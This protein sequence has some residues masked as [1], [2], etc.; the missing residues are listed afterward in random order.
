MACAKAN[1]S[2]LLMTENTRTCHPLWATA[3][4]CLHCTGTERNEFVNPANGIDSTTGLG[5]W[6]PELRRAVMVVRPEFFAWSAQEQLAY[7]VKLPDEDREALVAALLREHGQRRPAALA[8]LESRGRV[9]LALQNRIN[10][11]LQ[12]LSGIGEDA[13][14]LN[15]HFAEGTSILDFET[16]LD[17]DRDD[18]T[19][20]QEANQREFEGYQPEPYT[21]ALYGTWARVLVEGQLCYLTLTMASGQLLDAM[22]EAA[23]AEIEARIPHH[24]VPGPDDGKRDERGSIRWDMRVDANGQETL[25]EEL[26]HRVWDEQSRRRREL[27]QQFCEQHRGVCFLDDHPWEHGDPNE[28]NLLVVFS[29][30][31][32]L[33]A[34]R[35]TSFLRDCRRLERPLAELRALQACE[36]QR[37]REFV[38]AQHEDL[39]KNFD[40]KV[41]TLR[42]KRKMMFHP[43]ALRDLQDDGLV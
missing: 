3:Q 17:Y 1:R 9:P 6:S 14:A 10:E 37:M 12:P 32:A 23:R 2:A 29:D 42:K 19:F 39:V 26:Q 15:E 18:H 43:E 27:G 25:L 24:L 34:V 7:R 11:W 4:R 36:A 30:P 35:F 22:E 33:A 40:P 20:Q 5:R 8:K 21:G 38:A 16:L 31:D 28:R 13:F 41:V